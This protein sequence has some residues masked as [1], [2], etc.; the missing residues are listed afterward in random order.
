M[1]DAHFITVD[2]LSTAIAIVSVTVDIV[3]SCSAEAFVEANGNEMKLVRMIKYGNQPC[4][5][6]FRQYTKLN[7]QPR[8]PQ[9]SIPFHRPP[10][11][12]LSP[13]FYPQNNPHTNSNYSHQSQYIPVPKCP[14]HTHK[15]YDFPHHHRSNHTPE[16]HHASRTHSIRKSTVLETDD[17]TLDTP[18]RRKRPHILEGCDREIRD[19]ILRRATRVSSFCLCSIL[20]RLSV[21]CIRFGGSGCGCLFDRCEGRC[22]FLQ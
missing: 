21:G 20:G 17:P 4:D 18:P 19:R 13:T 12:M 3:S 10:P 5:E 11:A 14:T 16:Q 9:H 2:I 8:T 1:P 7:K 22:Y 15:I 6:I